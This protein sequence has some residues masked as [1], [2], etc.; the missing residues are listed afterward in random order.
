MAITRQWLRN[1]LLVFFLGVV[2][3]IES[4]WILR[5]NGFY[6]VDE[7][8]HFLYSRFVLSAL[9]ETVQTWHRPGRL[10]LFALP[11]Q[12]GHPFTM[13]F[14]LALFLCLLLVTY[15]TAVLMNIRHAVWVVILIGL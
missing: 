12:L 3:V 2:A 4:V 6:P 9:P 10:W 14:C 7:C 5:S 11:A 1:P 13:F 15:R 8:A